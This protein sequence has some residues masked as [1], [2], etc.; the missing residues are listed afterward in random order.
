MKE[1]NTT[2][3]KEP[4]EKETAAPEEKAELVNAVK[5]EYGIISKDTKITGNIKTEGHITIEGTV[6][7]NIEAKGNVVVSGSVFGNI[8]C[9]N[10]ILQNGDLADSEIT[11]KGHVIIENG[12]SVKGQVKCKDITIYGKLDGTAEAK[13][14]A[15]IREDGIFSGKLKAGRLGVHPGAKITGTVNISGQN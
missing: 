6:K 15:E 11:A 3:I 10:L 14:K 2:E 1:N 9:D 8:S 5:D 13:E 7:G 4:E 12:V